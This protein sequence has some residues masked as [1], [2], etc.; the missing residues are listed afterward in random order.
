MTGREVLH[1]LLKMDYAIN[2][3]FRELDAVKKDI[4]SVKAIS[5]GERVQTSPVNG[6][7]YERAV[8]KLVQRE[9]D[10]TAMIDE[11]VDLKRRVIEAIH[12]V[13]D[14]V[15][16]EFLTAH[17]VQGHKLERIAEEMD[18]SLRHIYRIKDDSLDAFDDVW[19]LK[20]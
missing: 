4:Y 6:A 3:L 11:F 7:G 8:E 18:Y 1:E 12:D 17:Y 13:R 9:L 16:R 20:E 2:A 5:Y 10:A 14:P 15:K 19:R